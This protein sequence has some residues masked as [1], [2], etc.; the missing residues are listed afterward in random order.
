ME[1]QAAS[2]RGGVDVLGQ[3]PEPAAALLDDF[4]YVEKI[5]KGPC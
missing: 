1:D 5:A 3:R 2:G 4:H